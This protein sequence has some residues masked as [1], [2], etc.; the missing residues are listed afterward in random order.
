MANKTIEQQMA[1][2]RERIRGLESWFETH[3]YEHPDY[4]QN[5]GDLRAAHWKLKQLINRRDRKPM[6]Y[7]Q[8]Y[9]IGT[10]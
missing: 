10:L 9:E 4:T 2:T 6:K 7:G 5:L 3:D 1:D 8:T